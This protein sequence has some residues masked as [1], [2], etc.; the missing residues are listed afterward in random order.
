M[1]ERILIRN[2]I[3]TKID[4]IKLEKGHFRM[5]TIYLPLHIHT[6]LHHTY[7]K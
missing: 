2:R 1:S 3:I 4:A 7:S 6:F 5:E